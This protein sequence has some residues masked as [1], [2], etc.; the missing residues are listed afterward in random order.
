MVKNVSFGFFAV[1][2]DEYKLATALLILALRF[3]SS[4]AICSVTFL[5][6]LLMVGFIEGTDLDAGGAPS[7]SF[8]RLVG[9]ESPVVSAVAPVFRFFDDFAA[10]L[11]ATIFSLIFSNSSGGGLIVRM[12]SAR[13]NGAAQ[14]GHGSVCGLGGESISES[15]GGVL[16][17]EDEVEGDET[18]LRPAAEKTQPQVVR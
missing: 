17:P 3:F 12:S 8:D 15:F 14:F 18:A 1:L 16:E 7:S 6:T 2:F 11:A 5:A 13:E 10:A 9:T 4:S